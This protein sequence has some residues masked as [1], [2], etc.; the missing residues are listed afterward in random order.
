LPIEHWLSHFSNYKKLSDFGQTPETYGNLHKI[1][2]EGQH[3]DILPLVHPRQAGNLGRA[4]KKWN[5]L[6]SQW[7]DTRHRK[8][9]S[10]A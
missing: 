2:I 9:L 1:E 6:H 5:E 4:S 10:N 7:S 3:F 8:I